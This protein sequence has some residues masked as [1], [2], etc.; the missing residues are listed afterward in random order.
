MSVVETVA[1][2][3]PVETGSERTGRRWVA[4]VVALLFLG[5]LVALVEPLVVPRGPRYVAGDVLALR[6]Q[7]DEPFGTVLRYESKHAFP[8]G[9]S[10]PAY[11]IRL[12][13]DSARVWF[14]KDLVDGGMV[15]SQGE[16]PTG[17]H[18]T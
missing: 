11:E 16:Q 7:P 13:Q 18:R 12:R 17:R 9:R 3:R 1:E 15:R 8:G 6:E 14:G 2:E 10:G 4:V 5:A